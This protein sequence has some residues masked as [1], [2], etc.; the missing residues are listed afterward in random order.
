MGLVEVTP[1]QLREIFI[2]LRSMQVVGAGSWSFG[3]GMKH[4][5]EYWSSLDL[6]AANVSVMF[7]G[8]LLIYS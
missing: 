3:F 8:Q 2:V 1:I 6:V 7:L 4:T 5:G